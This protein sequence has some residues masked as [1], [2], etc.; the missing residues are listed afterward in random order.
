MLQ[1]QTH[2]FGGIDKLSRTLE[3]TQYPPE[4]TRVQLLDSLTNGR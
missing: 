3:G 2:A 4:A 1:T